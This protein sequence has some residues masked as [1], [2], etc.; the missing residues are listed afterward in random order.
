MD[1][2]RPTTVRYYDARRTRPWFVVFLG[3]VVLVAAVGVWFGTD[4]LR[5]ESSTQTGVVTVDGEFDEQ[6]ATEGAQPV[7]TAVAAEDDPI[8]ATSMAMVGDS[9]TAASEDAIRYTLAANG[10]TTMDIDGVVSRRI[11]EGDGSNGTPLNGVATLY[12]MLGDPEITPDVWVVALGTNDV[13]QYTD[14]AE[15]R[16]LIDTVLQMIP[17]DMPLVWVDTYRWDHRDASIE[18][19]QILV[20]ELAGRPHSVVASWHDQASRNAETRVLRDDG[21]HPNEHGTVVFSALVAEGIAA[22]T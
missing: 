12:G 13:G 6:A 1:P 21:V 4:L 7:V 10:F 3:V 11:L 15:Y 18:F 2:S 16:R 14:P 17:V 8:A 22:V 19:N 9:I 20:E 5:A